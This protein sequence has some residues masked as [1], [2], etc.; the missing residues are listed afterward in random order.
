MGR[1]A[2]LLLLVAGI[3]ESQTARDVQRWMIEAE[4]GD[5]GAA[6][7]LG[8]SYEQG[9]GVVQ[10]LKKAMEW[11]SWSAS[12]GNA[13]AQ[14]S[15]G[16]LFEGGKGVETDYEQAASWFRLA[17]ENR[18]DYGGAGQGC[19]NLGLLYLSGNGVPK[20]RVEAYKYFKIA[21]ASSNLDYVTARMTEDEI[22]NAESRVAQWR[23]THPETK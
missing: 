2:V 11:F 22:R 1:I 19:S 6:F 12:R 15:M 14:N 9:K 21:N 23:R 10:D 13:D 5:A 4:A 18:P 7:W 20:D 3:A 17:C 8:V 16:Q